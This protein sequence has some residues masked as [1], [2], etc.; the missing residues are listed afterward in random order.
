MSAVREAIVLP[1]L[2]LSVMLI[3]AVRI[4]GSVAVLAPSVYSIVLAFMLLGVL[5][6]S[7]TLAPWRLMSASRTPLENATGAVVIVTV[8]GAAAQLFS[9]MTPE[10]GLPYV[11]F[12]VFFLVLLL[13]TFTA[14]PDRVRLLRSLTVIFGSAF[15]LKFVVLAALSGPGD[16]ALARVLLVL[17]EGVT[18]GTVTQDPQHPAAAYLALLA[19]V[20]FLLGTALLPPAE[21]T[22]RALQRT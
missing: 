15:L 12:S 1:L 2:F 20:L 16:G 8:I 11:A 10:R 6:R 19:L 5:V 4:G 21:P 18:L 3:G 13:N 7:G 22:S 9:L 17:L 14:A